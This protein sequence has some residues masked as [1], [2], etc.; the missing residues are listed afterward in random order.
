MHDFSHDCFF[1]DLEIPTICGQ[2]KH[3]ILVNLDEIMDKDFNASVFLR[4][5]KVWCKQK[6]FFVTIK[7]HQSK[8]KKQWQL[9]SM[10]IM[11]G[12]KRKTNNKPASKYQ[13][14]INNQPQK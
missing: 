9:Q 13:K 1:K 11:S 4:H 10:I 3:E 7:C 6:L 12:K 8:V 14:T 2:H 5:I